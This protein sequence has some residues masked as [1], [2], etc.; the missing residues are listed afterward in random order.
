MSGFLARWPLCQAYGGLTAIS[1]PA[2]LRESDVRQRLR[3]GGRARIVHAVALRASIAVLGVVGGI[4]GLSGGP[5]TGALAA[6]APMPGRSIVATRV[7]GVV[8]VESTGSSGFTVLKRRRVI[9]VGSI[10]DASNGT[11][12]LTAAR[13]AHGDTQT[14]VSGPASFASPSACPRA[15]RGQ[16][17]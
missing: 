7:S 10:I 1:V 11:V 16:L 6:T 17:C 8:L 14:D 2:R 9:P 5:L 13:D 3:S 12:E 4:G 15:W